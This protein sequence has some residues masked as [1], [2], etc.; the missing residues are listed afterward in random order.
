MPLTSHLTNRPSKTSCVLPGKDEL[1][2]NILHWTITHGQYTRVSQPANVY[3]HQFF[4]D[5]GCCLE[6]FQRETDREV[7]R[8]RERE[9]GG[10]RVKEEKK[11]REYVLSASFNDNH[12]YQPLRS[13][14]I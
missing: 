2:S 12:I 1:I 11:L 10:E 4:A 13:G 14:R 7:D 6:D 3:I 5:T 9:R 8:E